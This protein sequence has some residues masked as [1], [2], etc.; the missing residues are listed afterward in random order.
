MKT[1]LL[2]AQSLEKIAR[3]NWTLDFNTKLLTLLVVLADVFGNF[4]MSWGLKQ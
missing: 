2:N 1:L 3:P 4:T